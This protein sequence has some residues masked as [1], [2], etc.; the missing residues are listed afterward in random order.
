MVVETKWNLNGNILCLND[1]I[2]CMK[3]TGCDGVMVAET[4]L[5][6]PTV[7]ANLN[8]CMWDIASEYLDF[9][10][11]YP[12]HLSWIRGHIFKIYQKFCEKHLDFRDTLGK[13]R[14]IQELRALV[15]E[16]K[17]MCQ[18]EVEKVDKNSKEIF[19]WMCQAHIRPTRDDESKREELHQTVQETLAVIGNDPQ[20]IKLHLDEMRKN[21]NYHA[22]SLNTNDPDQVDQSTQQKIAK[23]LERKKRKQERIERKQAYTKKHLNDPVIT[24]KPKYVDCAGCKNPSGTN[25]DS[26]MCR[27][28]CRDYVYKNGLKCDSHKFTSKQKIETNLANDDLNCCNNSGSSSN[29]A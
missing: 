14:N 6:N 19:Y 4:S 21:I 26:K 11:K 8:P 3:Q 10:D 23:L 25:C 5:Y 28:C 9:V 22:S 20:A 16:S 27:G 15:E 1:V 7:F 24:K 17:L 18:S 29:Q 12:C 2:E 13:A